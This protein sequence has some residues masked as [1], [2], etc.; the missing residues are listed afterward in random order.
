M[1]SSSGS[2]G[3]VVGARELGELCRAERIGLK[4][5]EGTKKGSLY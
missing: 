5:W 2:V 4:Y 3:D 1:C